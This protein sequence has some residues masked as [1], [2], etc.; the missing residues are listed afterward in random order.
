MTGNYEQSSE[1][2]GKGL[3]WLVAGFLLGSWML[4]RLLRRERREQREEEV[5][6][7]PV[8]IPTPNTTRPPQ[9]LTEETTGTPDDLTRIEGVGPKVA[10]LLQEEGIRTYAQLAASDVPRLKKILR[11]HGLAFM[12]PGTW[13]Q[14]AGLAAAGD[15]Q[16]LEAL[17]EELSAGRR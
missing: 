11:S 17:Q 13:P 12:N 3:S 1:E 8:E 7:Q 14:Q 6:A 2:N 4:W 9:P 5:T 16:N 15:W 10:D